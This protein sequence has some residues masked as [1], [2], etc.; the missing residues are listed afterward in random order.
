MKVWPVLSLAAFLLV[1][2]TPASALEY[3]LT[4]HVRGQSSLAWYPENHI[5]SRAE[6]QQSFFDSAVDFRVNS[7]IFLSNYLNFNFAYEAAIAGGQSRKAISRLPLE[8]ELL[9]LFRPAVPSDD[10]Q[11]FSLTHVFARNDD[12]IGYHRIDRLSLSLDTDYGTIAAGRQ[13]L[14]WGNGLIFNPLDLINPFSPTDIIR[15]YKAG[16]DMLLYQ[17]GGNRITDFQLVYVPRRDPETDQPESSLSTFGTR[18][19]IS[20]HEL[21]FDLLAIKNYEDPV[22]GAELTGYIGD[23]VF[24]TDFSITLAEGDNSEQHYLSA[25]ANIDYSWTWEEKNWYGFIELYHNGFGADNPI[26]ALQSEDLTIRLLRGELFVTGKW[27]LDGMLRYEA[28]PLVNCFTSIII[29]LK[30][31]SF[32]LQPRITWDMSDS[33]QLTG[34]INLPVGRSG[35]EFGDIEYPQEDISSGRGVQGYA[36]ATW[37]F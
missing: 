26:D 34:G 21:D 7:S 27:Y 28:H 8:D 23:A 4:G 6:G 22:I 9:Q 36:L 11:L 18:L 37:F 14:T 15:D 12:Y 19:Q 2:Q 3:E 30:D 35:D 24:R 33:V 16:A 13:A 1:I 25:V 29:N 20:Y 5:L 17:V 32:L 31:G 10:G